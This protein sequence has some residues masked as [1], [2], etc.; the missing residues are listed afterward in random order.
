LQKINSKN[1]ERLTFRTQVTEV[2]LNNTD[3]LHNKYTRSIEADDS[4][5]FSNKAFIVW[6]IKPVG[7][8]GIS[9]FG[10]RLEPTSRVTVLFNGK[11]DAP[12]EGTDEDGDSIEGDGEEV[13]HEFD[14][15]LT[16]FEAE[17]KVENYCSHWDF[18]I[19]R[20]EI[21]FEAKFI[22]LII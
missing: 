11:E 15:D 18:T 21:D 14:F 12:F 1:M 6:S 8:S 17:F 22:K 5:F 9:D 2:H 13:E 7:S 10:Y 16:G 20:I 4:K 3:S 19:T